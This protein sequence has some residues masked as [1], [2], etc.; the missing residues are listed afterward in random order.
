MTDD[1]A[2][3]PKAKAARPFWEEKS[4]AEM[5]PEEWES[6]CDGCGK[7][8]VVLLED[9]EDEETF[10][11]TSVC[12]QL[13]DPKER[14][15]TRYD[16]RFRLVPD[17][18]QVTPQNA[19]ALKWMPSSCAYRRLAEGRGLAAWHPLVSGRRESVAEAGIAVAA[20]L[21]NEKKVRLR[22]LWRFVVGE[23]S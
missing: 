16:E 13:F 18:V 23:R 10:H 9:D 11:E 4:L 20:D 21:T 6:L 3:R 15:C 2:D 17:C 12:C 7:C 5:T 14:R 1:M 19:G 8:C 22:N